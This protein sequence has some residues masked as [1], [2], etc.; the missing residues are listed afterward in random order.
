[1]SKKL[2]HSLRSIVCKHSSK[3]CT[4]REYLLNNWFNENKRIVFGGVA[5]VQ[6]VLVDDGLLQTLGLLY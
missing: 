1:M 3:L 2:N 5:V 6:L 4:Q